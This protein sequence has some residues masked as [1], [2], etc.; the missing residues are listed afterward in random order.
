MKKKLSVKQLESKFTSDPAELP[1][2]T[3]D[4]YSHIKDM[5]T[6]TITHFQIW[7]EMRHRERTDIKTFVLHIAG[8]F[9]QMPENKERS[10][11]S[12]MSAYIA[13]GGV[14]PTSV[15]HLK[16]TTDFIIPPY[17][18]IM[19]GKIG[20]VHKVQFILIGKTPR[21]RNDNKYFASA[22]A[23]SYVEGR[24]LSVH[25]LRYF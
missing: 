2:L 20:K 7:L 18:Q 17:R 24:I 25:I 5:R 13:A 15:E 21:S 19:T 9:H 10:L 23:E 22:P 1:V 3:A 4:E 6:D 16:H 12:E 11:V 8:I 14:V